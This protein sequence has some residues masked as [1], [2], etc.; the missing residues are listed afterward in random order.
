[1][2]TGGAFIETRGREGNVVIDAPVESGQ[3]LTGQFWVSFGEDDEGNSL[4]DY[5]AP[6]FYAEYCSNLIRN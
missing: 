4:G 2:V 1:M 6:W 5:E 3:P